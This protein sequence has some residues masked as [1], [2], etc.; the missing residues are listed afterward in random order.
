VNA[1]F[2]TPSLRMAMPLLRSILRA[3]H[4][5][6]LVL[7]HALVLPLVVA[8]AIAAAQAGTGAVR[9]TVHDSLRTE[10]PLAGVD[11]VLLGAN[12]RVRTDAAGRFEFTGVPLGAATVVFAAPWLDSLAL[13]P[14]QAS[15]DVRESSVASMMLATPSRRAYQLAVCG[16]ALADTEGILIGELRSPDGEAVAGVPVGAKWYETRI[17]TG[18]FERVVRASLDSSN[19]AGFYSLCG[20]PTDAEVALVAATDSIASG[21]IVLGLNGA[22]VA[23][24]D[25]TVAPSVLPVRVRG[26]LLGADS[27]GLANAIVALAG[28][29]SRT[30]RTD[31]DGRFSLPAV[32]RRSSQLVAR[33]LGFV[34]TLLAIDPVGDELE[35][36]DLALQKVPYD[37]STVTVTGQAMTAN[38]LQFDVRRERG[39]GFFISDSVLAKIPMVNSTVISSMIPRTAIQQTRQGPMIQLRRGSGFCR[40]RF[41]IDGYD[42]GNISAEEE[43]NLM[44]RAKRV[45]VYTASNAP[46]QFNDFDGCG[47]IV[48][49]TR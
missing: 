19:A 45:E 43:G 7:V 4:V 44:A 31:A 2:L 26:R 49:W 27:A 20:V 34:P 1:D 22:P 11:V 5:R 39:I 8:P 37:L 10:A 17:G 15:V 23:R 41:F 21:E 30:A 9:G 38:Q 12:R 28:D 47:V 48:V 16:V 35:L 32:P 14:L 40:P 3:A 13:P 33:A 29:S 6:R 46:P 42:N 36:E 18:Q 24:R 25:L